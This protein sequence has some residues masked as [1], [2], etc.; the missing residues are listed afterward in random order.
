MCVSLKAKEH[1]SNKV[2]GNNFTTQTSEV[3][4]PTPYKVRQG[5]YPLYVICV[6]GAM[7]ALNAKGIV[8]RDLK[9]QNILLCHAGHATNPHPS[10]IQLKIGKYDL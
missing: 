2:I 9:P 7:V 8:H 1:S 4:C 10:E 3:Y 6:A 5:F